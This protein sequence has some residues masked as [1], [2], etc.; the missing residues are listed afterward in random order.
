MNADQAWQ[1]VLGQLQTE[2][3]RASF[4]TWV[5]DTRPLLY[6]NGALTVGVPNAYARDWLESRLASRVSRL[7]IGILNSNVAVNFVVAQGEEEFD[8]AEAETA[9][10]G[11]DQPAEP[12]ARSVPPPPWPAAS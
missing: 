5:R 12:R 11:G 8:S 3:P 7:L 2:M 10:P 9:L 6:E 4:D 1:S